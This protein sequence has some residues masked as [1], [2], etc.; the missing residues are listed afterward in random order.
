MDEDSVSSLTPL[1]PPTSEDAR[2]S[3][4]RLLRSRRVGISTFYRLMQENETAERALEVLPEVARAAGV[5]DYAIAPL[6]DI[7][8]EFA[9]ARK[10]GARMICRGE[11][12]YPKELANIAD[13]PPLFWAIGDISLLKRPK[14][15]IVGARN[16]S[17]LGERMARK[18][19]EG[20]SQQGLIVVSGLA[21]G[22]DAVCH[23]A[24]LEGGTIAV[25]AGGVDKIYPKENTELFWEI[26]AKGLRISEDPIGVAPQA[27][28]F[29]KR[30]RIISG[31]SIGL[32]VVEAAARSG[33]LI[34][35][36]NALD[37]GREVMAVPGHPFDARATG[38][39]MLIRDGAALIRNV[40]DILEQVA[41]ALEEPRT[42]A[43]QAEPDEKP[44]TQSTIAESADLHR[45]ILERLGPSPL[46]EDQLI[47]DLEQ[48]AHHVTAELVSLEVEGRIERAPGGYLMRVG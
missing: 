44:C 11:A 3:W 39:N 34:T 29:P 41:D 43:D 2:L 47:R 24:A 14:I 4:L 48:P 26:G 22:I 20:L 19:S 35:A 23:K 17:S 36:R 18:L 25:Q 27:R 15:G 10:A 16:A 9:A 37:Q 33:T 7:E 13:A 45:Q 38:S 46:A 42:V 5:T 6:K 28:H 30:N 40:D 31:L 1:T 12:D 21:R 32:V 8:N